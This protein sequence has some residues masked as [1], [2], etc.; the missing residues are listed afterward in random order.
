MFK[1]KNLFIIIA[2]LLILS[3]SYRSYCAEVL[4]E[5]TVK[6][7]DTLWGVAN[8][9]LKNPQRWPEI[10]KYNPQ[11]SS[12]PNIILPGMRIKVPVLLIKENLRAAYLVYILND[13]RYRRRNTAEW[14]QSVINMELYNEDALRTMQQSQANVRFPSGELMRVFENSIIILRPDRAEEEAELT[15]GAVRASRAKIVSAEVTIQPKIQPRSSNPD[16]RASIRPSDQATLVEVYDGIVDVTAQGKTVTLTKGFGTIARLRQPPSL[17]QPLPPVPENISPQLTSSKTPAEVP[18]NLVNIQLNLPRLPTSAPTTETSGAQ[19]I[20]SVIRQ[21]HLQIATSP[22]FE[23][24][25]I[26]ETREI[27]P[28]VKLDF[29]DRSLPDGLY[30][31]RIAYVDALGLEGKFSQPISFR[32]DNTAPEISI[33]RPADNSTVEDDYIQI[34]GQVSADTVYL[35]A[36]NTAAKLDSTGKFTVTI[37]ASEGNNQITLIARDAAKNENRKTISVTRVKKG[38]KTSTGKGTSQTSALVGW[39]LGALTIVVIIGVV[40]LLI[41]P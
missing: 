7:G 28:Q 2:G 25:I 6:E 24:P 29:N 14:K 9:Y 31:Y 35:T 38:E 12:D 20:G 40:A 17:P 34:E 37:L 23:N 36:N 21:Y 26:D 41:N 16:Y 13:V 27:G 10:L 39:G 30:Y 3:L 1:K 22:N 5:I 8:F 19:V 4:Q 33:H 32:I 11:L 18:I 15:S